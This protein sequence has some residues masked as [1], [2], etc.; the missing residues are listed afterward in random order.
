MLLI[1]A[2]YSILLYY[3]YPFK[4]VVEMFD[5]CFNNQSTVIIDAVIQSKGWRELRVMVLVMISEINKWVK[6]G[7]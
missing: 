4:S 6:I 3:I 1:V 2:S 7:Q 5:E